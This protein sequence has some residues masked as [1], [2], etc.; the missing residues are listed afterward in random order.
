MKKNLLAAITLAVALIMPT[1]ALAKK[2]DYN[3]E[4]LVP[5]YQVEGA[6]STSDNS[7]LVRVYILSKKKNVTD[8]QL[9]RCAVHAVLFRDIDDVTNAGYGSVASKKAIM[10]TPA[11]EAQYIDF[12]E[13]FFRNGDCN[14]YVQL[15]SN[16]RRVVK[17]GK[18]YKTSAEVKVNTAQLKKDLKSQG[19]VKDL[20]SGW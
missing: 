9:G 5:E 14:K 15:V 10:R 19:M 12:F 7:Q 16:S 1:G 13:P 3:D 4:G 8:D 6:G 2:T 18:Q 20:G 11:A 17:V